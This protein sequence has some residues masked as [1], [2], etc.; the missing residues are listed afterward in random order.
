MIRLAPTD[1]DGCLLP[2]S[3]RPTSRHVV[4][5]LR[6]D[7]VLADVGRINIGEQHGRYYSTRPGDGYGRGLARVTAGGRI[8]VYGGRI[9]ITAA[10][11]KGA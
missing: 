10:D 1:D 3:S 9:W 6:R 11:K 2:V 5:A 8:H 7:G 4:E